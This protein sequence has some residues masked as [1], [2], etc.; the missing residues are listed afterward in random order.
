MPSRPSLVQIAERVGVS[1][2]TVSRAFNR[3]ELLNDAT[4]ERILATARQLGF[5]PSKVG[6]SLRSGST[7]TL[8]LL[9]PTM[10]NPVFA[11][12]FEGA[13]ERALKAGYSVMLATTGY[14]ARRE[15]EAARSLLD[16]RV[17]GMILTVADPAR[18]A[19]LAELAASGVPFVLAY[20]ESDRHPFVS[21]DNFA[22]AGDMVEQLV[23]SGHRRLAMIS[24]PLDASDRASKRLDGVL[25]RAARLDLPAPTHVSMPRHTAADRDRLRSLL[26]SPRPPSALFCSN[27]LL[28]ASVI[29]EL[30]TLGLRVPDDLSVC[31][32]DGMAFGA[33]MVPSLASVHQPSS[34]IGSQACHELL[35]ALAGGS[36][37]SVRLPHRLSGGGTVAR[38][39]VD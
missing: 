18:S 8:G 10:S 20:N 28:A 2:A 38:L 6:S 15:R 13:E 22:A 7:R 9:L 17:E 12:C 39:A 16:H 3:P 26:S 23:A 32:F 27:D 29:A 1:P 30:A 37:R 5:R 21:V 14:D 25:D 19:T 31:G 24:G 33:L 34:E 4:R 35:K 36:S 11:A